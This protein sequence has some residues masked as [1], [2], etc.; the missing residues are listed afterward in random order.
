MEHLILAM[1]TEE[2]WYM[3]ALVPSVIGIQIDHLVLCE[4]S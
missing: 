4:L 3:L 2:R 1:D